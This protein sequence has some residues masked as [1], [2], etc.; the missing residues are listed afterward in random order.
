MSEYIPDNPP[1]QPERTPT[2]ADYFRAYVANEVE[3]VDAARAYV[4]IERADPRHRD[5]IF[6]RRLAAAVDGLDAAR[7]E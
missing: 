4:A 5:T 6:Y 2:P 7:R 1:E 3:V